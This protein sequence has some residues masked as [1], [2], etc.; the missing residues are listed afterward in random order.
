MDMAEIAAWYRPGCARL[1]RPTTPIAVAHL[2]DTHIRTIDVAVPP[3]TTRFQ[4]GIQ[5]DTM[6][7]LTIH[8]CRQISVFRRIRD[9]ILPRLM[10]GALSVAAAEVAAP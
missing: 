5:L 2:G 9:L 1:A 4:I 8:L 3:G 7:D 6:F 10:C